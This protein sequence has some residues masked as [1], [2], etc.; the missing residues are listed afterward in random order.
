MK[1]AFD[2]MVVEEMRKG[3][4]VVISPKEQ[5]NERLVAEI[6]KSKSYE[7]WEFIELF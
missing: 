3:Q 7:D 2:E 4:H 6:M 5:K 1:A